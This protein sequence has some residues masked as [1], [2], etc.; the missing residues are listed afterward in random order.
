MSNLTKR[1]EVDK[2]TEIS[3][4]KLL[5]YGS[6]R[7]DILEK[8]NLYSL[9]D[10]E[11]ITTRVSTLSQIHNYPVLSGS[12]L[13][14]LAQDRFVDLE[15][16]ES[17]DNPSIKLPNEVINDVA[18]FL[19]KVDTT[20]LKNYKRWLVL[21]DLDGKS[22]KVLFYVY[23]RN[24]N[25]YYLSDD[26]VC[27]KVGYWDGKTKNL[28]DYFY[29]YKFLFSK[30]MGNHF[31][32]LLI[33]ILVLTSSI[34]LITPPVFSTITNLIISLVYVTLSYINTNLSVAGRNVEYKYKDDHIGNT[35]LNHLLL[36]LLVS[37]LSINS[38]SWILSDKESSSETHSWVKINESDK[39]NYGVK[40]RAGKYSVFRLNE[41]NNYSKS[42]IPFKIN[43][44][45]HQKVDKSK[46]YYIDPTEW[47]K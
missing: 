33:P 37:F 19:N 3:E 31:N 4:V 30:V 5:N 25:K 15:F 43:H 6:D 45:V 47:E 1:L 27:F 17:W 24:E 13:F 8:L 11:S 12:D 22:E 23:D 28:S 36:Y 41:V 14:K 29:P 7:S 44:E 34:A 38:L 26:L 39:L 16:T 20:N 10:S 46:I 42:L 32:R 21:G 2:L 40:D 35:R 18:T 9:R